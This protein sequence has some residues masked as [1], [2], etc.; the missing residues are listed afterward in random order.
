MVM[1][2]HLAKHCA[3]GMDRGQ[4]ELQCVEARGAMGEVTV[5][6]GAWQCQGN[7]AAQTDRKWWQAHRWAVVS[8]HARSNKR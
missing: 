3:Q 7:A 2:S 5:T 8:A 6:G 4:L 1:A